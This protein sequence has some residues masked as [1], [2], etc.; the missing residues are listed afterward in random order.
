M[1]K[2]L[3]LLALL[4][5]GSVAL[6][7][8]DDPTPPPET[9]KDEPKKD[10]PKKDEPKKEEPKKEEAA[11]PET[12]PAFKLKDLAGKERTL[13][14]FKGKYVVLEWIN[15]GCPF[16]KK[17]YGAGNMQALQK[18][19]T[20]KGVVWLSICSSAEGMEGNMTVK[21]WE[22]KQAEVKAAPTAV[23]LDAD[24]T[25]GRAYKAAR[26]PHMVVIGKEGEVLYK[27]AIDDKPGAKLTE[28]KD[29]RNY[30][31]EALDAAMAGKEI[32]VKSTPAYG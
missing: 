29:S 6:P 21:E 22:A 9:K 2:A 26:T 23:L 12:A 5:M 10:E 31:A 28:V 7:A 3:A 13:E 30:V 24:G 16:V 4:A 32:A 1:T 20:E 25:A 14:E 18:K 8:G 19:Y 15:H 27:G 11:K 17:Q